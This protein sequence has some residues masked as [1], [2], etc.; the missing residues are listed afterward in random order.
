MRPWPWGMAMVAVVLTSVF[1][2]AHL[3]SSGTTSPQPGPGTPSPQ[4]VCAGV[5]PQT[6]AQQYGLRAIGRMEKSSSTTSV[7]AAFCGGLGQPSSDRYGA[8]DIP[9]P[10]EYC[11]SIVRDM[12]A[13]RLP[14]PESKLRIREAQRRLSQEIESL[15]RLRTARIWAA[16]ADHAWWKLSW[17]LLD[18]PPS[19]ATAAKCPQ[20]QVLRC[21]RAVLDR[22]NVA[23][24]QET[25][26]LEHW[27]RVRDLLS[28]GEICERRLDMEDDGIDDFRKTMQEVL[29]CEQV[30]PQEQPDAFHDHR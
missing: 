17:Q 26:L 22:L 3:G 6:A 7:Y 8:H 5:H 18:K 28:A 15:A 14:E 2:L 29:Q 19:P 25:E 16:I 1:L 11:E 23:S 27:V 13:T 9:T 21:S 20:E 4:S 10:P 12:D 30:Q 24:A